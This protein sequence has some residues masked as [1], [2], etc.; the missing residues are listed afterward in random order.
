MGG[1]EEE[2]RAPQLSRRSRQRPAKPNDFWK[3]ITCK[4][5]FWFLSRWA[6]KRGRIFSYT[7]PFFRGKKSVAAV[8][9]QKSTGNCLSLSLSLSPPLLLFSSSFLLSFAL[10]KN[11]Q[12]RIVPCFTSLLCLR[13]RR[14]S[15]E[16]ESFLQE[17]PLYKG[18]FCT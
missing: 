18:I 6:I 1:M 8:R 12:W 10:V 11:C 15:C 5:K 4:K 9:Q 7:S 16:T 2:K 13:R 14:L 17:L 3:K